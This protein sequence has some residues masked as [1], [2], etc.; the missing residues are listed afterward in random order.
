[1]LEQS[2]LHSW[3]PFPP[4]S[5]IHLK[6]SRSGGVYYTMHLKIPPDRVAAQ[7]RPFQGTS[8]PTSLGAW[9][10][11]SL[12]RRAPKRPYIV[13]RSGNSQSRILWLTKNGRRRTGTTNDYYYPIKLGR[14]SYTPLAL[15]KT[16]IK[17]QRCENETHTDR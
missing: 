3:T 11:A 4:R 5:T 15:C 14:V 10:Q 1:M 16:G 8:S 7:T 13:A 12:R 6:L 17:R 2:C 9:G